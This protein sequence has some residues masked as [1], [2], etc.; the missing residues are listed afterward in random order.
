MFWKIRA[1]HVYW[2]YKE[3]YFTKNRIKGLA[4]NDQSQAFK[5]S[6]FPFSSGGH[7]GKINENTD[8]NW[9]DNESAFVGNKF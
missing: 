6:V 3:F 4:S 5:M 1:A 9:L 8:K 2:G 7:T